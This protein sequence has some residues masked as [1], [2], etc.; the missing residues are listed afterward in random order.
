M[1]HIECIG[2]PGSGKSTVCDSLL[3]I[4]RG[5]GCDAYHAKEM[6]YIF[7][8][9]KLGLPYSSELVLTNKTNKKVLNSLGRNLNM[10]PL[11][12][13]K[14][15]F[16]NPNLM[17]AIFSQVSSDSKQ[18]FQES[19]RLKWTFETISRYEIAKNTLNKNEIVLFDEGLAHRSNLLFEF[20]EHL[21]YNNVREYVN[22]IPVPDDLIILKIPI[23]MAYERM[24][25]RDCGFPRLYKNFDRSFRIQLLKRNDTLIEFV[26]EIL[27]DKGSCVHRINNTDEISVI[28]QELYESLI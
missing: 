12:L 11:Y 25:S 27:E 15:M 8:L 28:C 21:R 22:Q 4:L 14:F 20:D 13:Q 23:E 17:R 5:D 1:R 3:T 10:N 16:E 26:T 18:S 9:N 7:I 19:L 2:I 24:I 6:N